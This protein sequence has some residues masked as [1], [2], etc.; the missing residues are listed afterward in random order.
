MFACKFGYRE[1]VQFALSA[2]CS[3]PHTAF[4]ILTTAVGLRMTTLTEKY[5]ADD[6][7]KTGTKH[8]QQVS[9]T[10]EQ[11]RI[12]EWV[13]AAK[14]GDEA[15]FEAIVRA[16]ERPVFNLAFRMLNHYED[17][18]ETAQEIFVKVYRSL[19]GFE[20]RSKFSTWLFS[21]AAN[22]CRNRLRKQARL[23]AELQILDAPDPED[24]R[25]SI[26]NARE[27][28]PDPHERAAL[29]EIRNEV[30]K[31]IA[32]L[33]VDYREVIVLRELRHMSYEDIAAALEV[34]VGT[35]KSRI[36]RAR[37]MLKSSLRLLK[38]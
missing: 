3:L 35:V 5:P 19:S 12:E 24:D 29:H 8:P 14:E 13:L 1:C 36:A 37:N 6:P 10:P 9:N 22:M 23:R 18:A 11:A 28:G 16:F 32:A 33:P 21:L 27:E 7:H 38:T 17:A 2:V 30:E 25:I 34:S 4:Q 26:F 20:G 31:G 15:A